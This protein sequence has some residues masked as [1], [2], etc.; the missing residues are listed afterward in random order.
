MKRTHAPSSIVVG[1]D[2]SQAAIHAAEWAIDEAI[3][4][5]VALRLVHV[6]HIP[7]AP[8]TPTDDFRLDVEYAETVLR[9]AH[10]AVDATGNAVT[11]ETAVVRGRPDAALIDQ[12]RDAEMI[13]VGSVGIGRMLLGSTAA[14]LAKRAYCPVAIIRCQQDRPRSDTDWIAVVV[15][16]SPDSDSAVQQAMAEAQLRGAPVL[17]LGVWRWGL[18]E[19]PYDQLDRH[20]GKWVRQYPDI[21]VQPVAA[22][23]GA[24]EYLAHTHESV[25]L[26]VIGT[27][28]VEHIPSLIGP[29]GHPLLGH[30][31]CSVLVVR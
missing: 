6:T 25:Q 17:A 26:V 1:I 31:E 13:C 23:G 7:E 5:G 28:D 15:N 18:G 4:R 11:V 10:R 30:S 20:L 3:S 24:A 19:I 21:H 27:E 12:S 8:D 9:A 2:G 14:K 22:R 16:G 29:H